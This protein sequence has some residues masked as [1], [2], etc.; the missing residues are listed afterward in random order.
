MTLVSKLMNMRSTK[1][2][3]NK[4][5]EWGWEGGG[6]L[7]FLLPVSFKSYP[8][9]IPFSPPLGAYSRIR[10][11]MQFC[12]FL[13]YFSQVTVPTPWKPHF[14]IESLLMLQVQGSRYVHPSL[15]PPTLYQPPPPPNLTHLN[16]VCILPI[17]L[18]LVC[19]GGSVLRNG[20]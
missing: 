19:N 8:F 10:A 13:F 1:I 3:V 17:G 2:E 11:S 4:S 6:G 12:I 9:R 16:Q 20:C 14:P 5:R 18:E 7:T 15:Q